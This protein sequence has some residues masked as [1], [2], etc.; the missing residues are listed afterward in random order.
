[1]KQPVSPQWRPSVSRWR[2]EGPG[3]SFGLVRKEAHVLPVNLWSW[4]VWTPKSGRKEKELRLVVCGSGEE[5]DT[6]K[7]KCEEALAGLKE[8]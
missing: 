3:E 8:E 4:E 6:A 2:L 7:R 5:E 1:M